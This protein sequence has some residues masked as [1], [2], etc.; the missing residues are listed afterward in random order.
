MSRK[1]VFLLLFLKIH[2][3]SINLNSG[4]ISYDSFFKFCIIFYVF[5]MPKFY[6]TCSVWFSC[7]I[8]VHFPS[9][10]TSL[11]SFLLLYLSLPLSSSLSLTLRHATE[12]HLPKCWLVRLLLT[13]TPVSTDAVS[14][15]TNE[16]VFRQ[17]GATPGPFS[18][19]ASML[20]KQPWWIHKQWEKKT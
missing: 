20:A 1:V 2:L 18:P 14:S 6:S 13:E 16:K 9:S 3:A 12:I 8:W 15:N 11:S 10:A 5:Q 4:T 7:Y 19:K 17:L